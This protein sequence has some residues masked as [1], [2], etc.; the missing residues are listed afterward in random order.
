MV[1]REYER[2]RPV[3]DLA[4]RIEARFAELQAE[5]DEKAA[6]GEV[7]LPAGMPRHSPRPE[8]RDVAERNALTPPQRP[9][10]AH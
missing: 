9:A 10:I 1:I 7:A 8:R 6:R 2:H 5:R 3:A 4:E